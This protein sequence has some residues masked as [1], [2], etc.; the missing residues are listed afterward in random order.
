[1]IIEA[2][3]KQIIDDM[4]RNSRMQNP[5]WRFLYM[6]DDAVGNFADR[7]VKGKEKKFATVAV[8]FMFMD[9]LSTHVF[10]YYNLGIEGNIIPA[11]FYAA[12][13]LWEF[14]ILKWLAAGFIIAYMYVMSTRGWTKLERTGGRA[15]LLTSFYLFVGV[16]FWNVGM[17]ILTLIWGALK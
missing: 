3:A 4:K 2:E 9:S 10:L 13:L 14:E 1:M 7:W 16:V 11:R 6:I 8:F 5:I 15:G 17:M 12:G